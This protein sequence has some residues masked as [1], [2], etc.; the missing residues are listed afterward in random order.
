MIGQSQSGT[1]KTAAF[2]LTMLSR[3]DMDLQEPQVS[4][5]PFFRSHRS[6]DLKLQ[7]QAICLAPTRELAL[8]IISVVQQMGEYTPVTCFP[9]VRDSIPKG[10]GSVKHQIIV[11]TPG[12]IIDV[13]CREFHGERS[14]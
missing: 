3:I 14:R 13:G 12:T 11:G 5:S 6:T 4:S 2:A 8:Q 9:A 1:G 7:S 10:M